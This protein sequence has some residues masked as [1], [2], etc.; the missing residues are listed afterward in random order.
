MVEECKRTG[1]DI[2][3]WLAEALR[4]LPTHR[5]SDGHWSLMPGIL[6]LTT[7]DKGGKEVSL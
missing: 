6:K 5:A 7:A 1:T 2:Q 4:R 3:Q